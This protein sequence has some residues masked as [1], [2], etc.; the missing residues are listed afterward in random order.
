[1]LKILN[2]TYRINIQIYIMDES[3]DF[4]AKKTHLFISLDVISRENCTE[5][6]YKK[7]NVQLAN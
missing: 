2:K 3:K 7:K 1:M 4:L 6:F 5:H